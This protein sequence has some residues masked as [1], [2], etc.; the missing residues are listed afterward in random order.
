MVVVGKSGGARVPTLRPPFSFVLSARNRTGGKFPEGRQSAFQWARVP[1]G[2]LPLRDGSMGAVAGG[3]CPR[4]ARDRQTPVSPQTLSRSFSSARSR[5]TRP[6]ATALAL[7]QQVPRHSGVNLCG[8]WSLRTPEQLIPSPF[9]HGL[10]WRNSARHRV[11]DS[12]ATI[13][14]PRGALPSHGLLS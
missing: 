11:P 12:P 3:V 7:A 6:W 8:E 2:A 13:P 10:S 1:C 9:G 5:R 4:Q 14:P